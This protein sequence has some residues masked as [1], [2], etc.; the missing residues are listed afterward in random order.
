[1]P[2]PLILYDLGNVRRIRKSQKAVKV[3]FRGTKRV[4]GTLLL[5][6]EARGKARK[7]MFR[8]TKRVLG[9]LLLRWEARGKAE[10]V[11]FQ[12]GKVC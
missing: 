11:M 8:G 5:R 3:M 6:W 1:M 7:V 4:P 12:E 9:T 10:K 2:V